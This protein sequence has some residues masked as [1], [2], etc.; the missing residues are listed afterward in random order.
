L[1]TNAGPYPI[2]FDSL[3]GKKFMC[4]AFDVAAKRDGNKRYKQ[5]KIKKE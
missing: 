2:E 4:K 5:V 1:A 3:V